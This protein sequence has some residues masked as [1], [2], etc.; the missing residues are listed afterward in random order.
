MAAHPNG[1]G[2]DPRHAETA[3]ALASD[4][5]PPQNLEAEQGVIGGILLDNDVLHD[6]ALIL[7]P[8]DFYRDSHQILFK[9]I[10][11]LYD[12]GKP[13]DAIILSE[14]LK[15]RG[16]YEAIGGDETLG[17]ILNS[18]PHAAN[19]KYH[20]GIVR[21]KSIGRQI[22]EGANEIVREVY[23]NNLTGDELL[24]GAERRIFAIAED[25]GV[26]RNR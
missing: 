21:E 25:K 14:E 8:E 4:R 24:E 19:T 17:L 16:E 26:W 22:L 10:R 2:H 7:R 5:L 6:V 11:D 3:A 20:A 12:L 18:V 13:I 1:N 23:S 15:R 9:A